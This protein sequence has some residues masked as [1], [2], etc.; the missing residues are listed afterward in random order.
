MVGEMSAVE[1]D[2]FDTGLRKNV[3]SGVELAGGRILAWLGTKK[4]PINGATFLVTDYRST[5]PK[6]GTFRVRLVRFLSAQ[7]S[8]TIIVSY[9][10]DQ[11]YFLKPICDRII[12]SIRVAS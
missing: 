7:K 12:S 3:S 10:E 9:R 5:P 4:Q 11:E 2:N 8:F 6:S 1:V